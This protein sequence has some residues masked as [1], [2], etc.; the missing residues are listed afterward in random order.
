MADSGLSEARRRRKE[1]RERERAAGFPPHACMGHTYPHF[2]CPCPEAHKPSIAASGTPAAG[3]TEVTEYGIRI[4]GGK[5]LDPE[6][7][8][9]AQRARLVRYRDMFPG[10]ELVVR[11][12]TFGEWGPVDD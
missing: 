12:V 6:R 10:A 11:T 2:N 5:V 4:P 8:E 9:N 3:T 7:N 1:L